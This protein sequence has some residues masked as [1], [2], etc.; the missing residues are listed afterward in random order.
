MKKFIAREARERFEAREW[1]ELISNSR[2]FRTQDQTIFNHDDLP[3]VKNELSMTLWLKLQ[4]YPSDWAT[5]F[6]KGTEHY[7]R[8]PGLWL[9]AGKSKLHGRFS[10]NWNS[11]VGVWAAGDEFALHKW[12]HIAYT[13]SDLEKRLDVYIDG[14]WVGHFPFLVENVQSQKVTF[15]NG[16]LYIGKAFT[17]GFDGEI[18]NVRYFNW[19]LSV[20]EVRMD[21]HVIVILVSS[22]S[23]VILAST[24]IVIL[25]ST[26]IVILVNTS[27]V[28]L[29]CK[30]NIS[31]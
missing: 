23:I 9:T 24:S 25:A 5:I 13:L 12:Y 18:S 3:M 2:T 27:I 15:N 16:P 22:T 6:H 19:R 14:E 11:N 26:S 4:S 31:Y 28:R 17:I 20:E 30:Q 29:D 8:T 21:I 7:V 1:V 10:G